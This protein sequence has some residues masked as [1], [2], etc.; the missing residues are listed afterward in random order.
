LNLEVLDIPEVAWAM[1]D[2]E[3]L[4]LDGGRMV[5]VLVRE[6]DGFS[7]GA[8]VGFEVGPTLDFDC[9]DWEEQPLTELEVFR[10]EP[11]WSAGVPISKM[12]S[13]A[14]LSG[15]STGSGEA[16]SENVLLF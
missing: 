11:P 7:P 15:S 9:S 5:L 3:S 8:A 1:K 16:P 12:E 10:L 2:T 14:M 4:Y 13:G 6:K